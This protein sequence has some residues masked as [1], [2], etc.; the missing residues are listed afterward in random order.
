MRTLIASLLA[1]TAAA[2]GGNHPD[3]QCKI[4][5][6][7]DQPG[8]TDGSCDVNSATGN[9]WCS[10]QDPSCASGRRWASVDTGDGLSGQCEDTGPDAGVGPDARTDARPTTDANTTD[11]MPGEI[12][13]DNQAAEIVLGQP[14]FMTNTENTGGVSAQS[15]DYPNGIASDGTTL[16]VTDSGNARA[17]GWSPL[18]TASHASANL[19]LGKSSFADSSPPI[20][21]SASNIGNT[22]CG[23]AVAIAG[24]KLVIADTTRNRVLIWSP[25]PTTPGQ[26]ANAV[27]GQSSFSTYSSGNAST[28]MA[29]PWGVWTDGTRL[30]VAD[31]DNS[32]VLIWTSYPWTGGANLVLGQADFGSSTIVSPPTASSMKWPSAVYFDGTHFFVADSGNN[33]VLVFN[34]FPSTKDQ[35]ANYVIGQPDL[36]SSSAAVTASGLSNP[37][38]L[39]VAGTALFVADQTANRVLVFDPIPTS[40]GAS[41]KH[42]LGQPGPNTSTK[43]TTASQTNM[44]Q[45][46]G[47]VVVGKELYVVDNSQHRVLRFGLNLP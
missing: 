42:V 1:I 34:G 11:A 33:R 47:L 6:D 45:P 14:D 43:P 17:L 24:T 7:C 31:S 25:L 39:A 28:Q 15:L 30:A 41:A 8:F 26:A 23:P 46:A 22:C 37:K 29:H 40:S 5:P 2:C 18:P 16:W 3:V 20:G 21:I 27:L 38:A 35:A 9:R 36:I 12:V 4:S 10:Y 19:I 13:T 44:W 32:R